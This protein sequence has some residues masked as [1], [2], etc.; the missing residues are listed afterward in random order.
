MLVADSTAACGT[1]PV[2]ASVYSLLFG[3]EEEEIEGKV[4]SPPPPPKSAAKGKPP[5]GKAASTAGKEGTGEF[6]KDELAVGVLLL[7]VLL[8]P[9][10]VLLL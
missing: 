4:S 1:H 9:V 8:S 10:I 6:T 2:G 5:A 3:S 7:A